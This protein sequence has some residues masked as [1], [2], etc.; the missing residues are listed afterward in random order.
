VAISNG[1]MHF[2]RLHLATD[3]YT[4]D[5][6][7]VLGFD[8]SLSMDAVLRMSPELSAA[9]VRGVNDLQYLQ[10]AEGLIEIPFRAEGVIPRINVIPNLEY[11][12]KRLAVTKV[13]EIATDFLSKSLKGKEE[14]L[15]AGQ[16]ALPKPKSIEDFLQK[17]LA[18]NS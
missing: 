2:D 12:A 5:G 10:N 16:Q 9:I 14:N 4:L 17:A 11:A 1:Q 6:S 3:H 15:P 18:K 8:Q 13:Q 7:G